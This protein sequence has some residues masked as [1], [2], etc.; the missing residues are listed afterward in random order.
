MSIFKAVSDLVADD[1]SQTCDVQ[2]F[3]SPT[4]EERSA[5]YSSR[6]DNFAVIIESIDNISGTVR[7]PFGLLSAFVENV[8]PLDVAKVMVRFGDVQ[9]FKVAVHG[10]LAQVLVVVADDP[11]GVPQNL[12]GSTLGRLTQPGRVVYNVLFERIPNFSRHVLD[13][14]LV[15]VLEAELQEHAAPDV[16]KLVQQ[17]ALMKDRW[18]LRFQDQP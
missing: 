11:G 1:S 12:L 18:R 17:D 4:I 13:L 14:Q 6:N 16:G 3:R 7:N 2:E 5:N 8:D 10:L 15:P 9:G